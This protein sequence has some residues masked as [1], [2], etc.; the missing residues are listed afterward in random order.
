M[1]TRGRYEEVKI[2]VGEVEIVDRFHLFELG[3]WTSYWGLSGW[4]N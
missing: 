3:E 2:R 1:R 4:P